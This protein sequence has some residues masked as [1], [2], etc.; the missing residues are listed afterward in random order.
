MPS[1]PQSFYLKPTKLIPNSRYP[2][3][4]YPSAFPENAT[5]NDIAEHFEQNGWIKQW[6]YGMY[7]ASHYHSTTHEAL[8]VYSG[9]AQL[10]FGV[11]DSEPDVQ[12][13][14]ALVLNV[15]PGDVIVVPAGV[16]H[17]TLAE[18]GE[19]LMVGAYPVG[20]RQWDMNYGGEDKV[21]EDSI[22]PSDPVLGDDPKGLKGVWLE[23]SQRTGGGISFI[24]IIFFSFAA[25]L[26]SI[27][28]RQM[29]GDRLS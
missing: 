11:A 5:A 21:I 23:G 25:L 16:A 14:R 24:A 17:R 29:L 9:C 4:F 18:I 12:Q 7:R 28:A 22:P 27:L 6:S 13:Q 3:I 15:R 19:F 8:G 2:L 26:L 10:R 1:I 20:A